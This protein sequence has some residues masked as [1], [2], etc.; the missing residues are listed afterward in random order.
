M[1]KSAIQIIRDALFKV[2]DWKPQFGGEAS[3]DFFRAISLEKL[4]VSAINLVITVNGTEVV[5]R[6]YEWDTDSRL[7]NGVKSS[8]LKVVDNGIEFY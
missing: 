1:V 7:N 6:R 4:K 5:R 8:N 3:T 2:D